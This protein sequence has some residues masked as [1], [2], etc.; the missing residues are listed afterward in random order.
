MDIANQ[1]LSLER[2]GLMIP[3]VTKTNIKKIKQKWVYT[4]KP[5]KNGQTVHSKNIAFPSPEIHEKKTIITYQSGWYSLA[6]YI[7]FCLTQK[8]NKK[9]IENYYG[10][11]L[12]W[13]IMRCLEPQPKD[14]ILLVI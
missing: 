14:R 11:K 8:K 2:K 3:Y 9:E 6:L 4:G 13:A 5:I 10:T 7:I 1:M 12:Y